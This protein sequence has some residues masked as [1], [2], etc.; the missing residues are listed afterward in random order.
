MD[1][2]VIWVALALLLVW[3]NVACSPTY[4]VLRDPRTGQQEMC[5][6]GL[7]GW[8]VTRIMILAVG[9]TYDP[10]VADGDRKQRCIDALEKAGWER[11]GEQQ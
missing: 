6:P 4:V 10:A 1:T 5:G 11:V 8:D 3:G 2:K 9:G 7:S